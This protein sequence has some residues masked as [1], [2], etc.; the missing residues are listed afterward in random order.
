MFLDVAD[1]LMIAIQCDG[2]IWNVIH[3]EGI[4]DIS[5]TTF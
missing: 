4:R 1:H 3:F 2:I 5:V